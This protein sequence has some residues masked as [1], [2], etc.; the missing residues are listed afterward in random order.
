M[1][2][3]SQLLIDKCR[4]LRSDG[5]S[6]GKIMKITK[7]P[8]TTVYDH[9]FDIVL[10]LEVKE[11]IA[12][13]SRKRINSYIHTKRKGKAW[14]GRVFLKPQGWT[15]EF[16]FV[17]SHFMFDGRIYYG[18]CEYYNRSDYLI[19]TMKK[20]VQKIF[21]LESKIVNRGGGVKSIGYY[22]VELGEYI[23]QKSLELLTYIRTAPPEEKQVFLRSFFD[24]EGNVTISHN[25]KKRQVRGYQ[26]DS[27]ILELVK[28]L[29]NEFK[30]K[31]SIDRKYREI[32]IPRKQNL[33]K[34][35]E[36]IGFSN[37]IFINPKRKNSLWK[38]ELSKRQLLNMAIES[39]L[40]LGSPGVHRSV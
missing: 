7:L 16:L 13:E 24:D 23:R 2:K 30:I 38:R 26:H 36:E 1:P 10:P 14:P 15:T 22:N 27:K 9:I 21:G 11:K 35:R 28:D 8:K 25:G 32:I 37:G 6:L 40:P 3:T 34:F 29:L 31:S 33:I 17:I 19:E 18:G 20:R 12:S 5:F 39:Y 4:T